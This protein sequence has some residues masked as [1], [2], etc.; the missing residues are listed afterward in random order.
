MFKNIVNH[1]VSSIGGPTHFGYY[2]VRVSD[3]WFP[4]GR[5]GKAYFILRFVYVIK[6]F[7]KL[8]NTFQNFKNKNKNENIP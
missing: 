7:E 3:L 5:K 1:I 6:T 2:G 4:G 8:S